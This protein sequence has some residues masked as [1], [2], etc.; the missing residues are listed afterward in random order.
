M[1]LIARYG[2]GAKR[3]LAK[4]RA[5]GT[6]YTDAY[7]VRRSAT[8]DGRARTVANYRTEDAAR[9]VAEVLNKWAGQEV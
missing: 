3:V 7:P 2:V 8:A 4:V 9:E 5:S 1:A 6:V